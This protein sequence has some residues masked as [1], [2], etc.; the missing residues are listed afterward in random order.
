MEFKI[1][2]ASSDDAQKLNKIA[3][4]FPYKIDIESPNGRADAKSLLGT[5][6]LTMES[7]LYLITEDGADTSELEAELAAFIVK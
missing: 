1:Y 4:K 3:S 7:S 2:I 5:M 6:L